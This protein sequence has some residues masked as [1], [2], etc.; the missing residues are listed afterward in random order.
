ML[1]LSA[2]CGN[3]SI[4]N[5]SMTK[6]MDRSTSSCFIGDGRYRKIL[7]DLSANP[8]QAPRRGPWLD[9]KPRDTD[10]FNSIYP[11]RPAVK[12]L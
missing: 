11:Y 9:E 2:N 1:L 6:I 3:R 10:Y 4:R 5:V 7:S 12:E 8:M